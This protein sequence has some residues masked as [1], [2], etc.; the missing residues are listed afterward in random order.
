MK[1][2]NSNNGGWRF[3][4]SSLL[5]PRNAIAITLW[6][7]VFYRPQRLSA[8]TICHERCHLKQQAFLLVVPFYVIYGFSYVVGLLRYGRGDKAYWYMPMEQHAREVARRQCRGERVGL[9]YRAYGWVR[10]IGHKGA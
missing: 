10:F 4:R 6:P 9:L 8:D 2:K 1:S 5:T 7:M 3:V